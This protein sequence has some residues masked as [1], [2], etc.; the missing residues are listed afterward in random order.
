MPHVDI[1]VPIWNEERRIP[2]TLP[3]LL[4]YVGRLQFHANVIAVDNG[5]TDR[6]LEIAREIFKSIPNCKVLSCPIHG[7]GAAVKFAWRSSSADI[8]CYMDADLATDLRSFSDLVAPIIDGRA[9]LT[10][11][12]RRH[13]GSVIRRTSLRRAVSYVYYKFSNAVLG[14]YCRD[15]QCG[16]K[17]I[18][19]SAFISFE[20]ELFFDGWLFDTELIVRSSMAGFDVVSVPVMWNEVTQSSVY[21][22]RDSIRMLLG[23]FRL[24]RLISARYRLKDEDILFP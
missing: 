16:F 18:S 10:Y 12:D 4:E 17:A 2:L 1:V 21:L 11:G 22:C 9:H 6:S 5:S 19:R 24:R 7:R 23:L 8:L 14:S 13:P 20:N 15:F 3:L